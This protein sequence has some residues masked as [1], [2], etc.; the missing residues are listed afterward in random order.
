MSFHIQIRLEKHHS[1]T[2]NAPHPPPHT[3]AALEMSQGISFFNT[4]NP[5]IMD[6]RRGRSFQCSVSTGAQPAEKHNLQPLPKKLKIIQPRVTSCVQPA[7]QKAWL[8]P[9]T[10]IQCHLLFFGSLSSMGRD[11]TLCFTELRE[12]MGSSLVLGLLLLLLV[13]S[14]SSP[15]LSNPWQCLLH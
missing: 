15:C 4:L 9:R 13:K 12:F 5:K 7:L 10:C 8:S 11:K 2:L 3:Q 6:E 1:G 14:K